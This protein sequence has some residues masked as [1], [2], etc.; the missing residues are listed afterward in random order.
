[1]ASSLFVGRESVVWDALQGRDDV[2]I[3]HLYAA[4]TEYLLANYG[5]SPRE[6]EVERTVSVR[7]KQQRLGSI[8]SSMN[9][10]LRDSGSTSKIK[11]GSGRRTYRIYTV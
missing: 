9:R 1:M 8:I 3:D 10:K 4:V 6:Q 11:P 2:E 5:A 7:L